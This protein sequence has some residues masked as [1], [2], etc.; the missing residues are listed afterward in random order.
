MFFFCKTIWRIELKIVKVF[1]RTACLIGLGVVLSG[2]D[3][4]G[5][6]VEI[7]DS[8]AAASIKQNLASTAESG[9][10]GSEM[11]AIEQSL[12]KLESEDAAKGA[13]VKKLFEELK[14][15]TTPAA[16]K[17]KAKEIIGKL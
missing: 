3:S 7:I 5:T 6:P 11:M 9:S 4:K 17:S 12:G 2:C 14:K 10:L 15:A 8:G 13:T 16:V 1:Y